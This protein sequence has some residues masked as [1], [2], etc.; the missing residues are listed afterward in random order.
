M[1][2]KSSQVVTVALQMRVISAIG[3][4]SKNS[5]G[6]IFQWQLRDIVKLQRPDWVDS[7]LPGSFTEEGISLPV[8]LVLKNGGLSMTRIIAVSN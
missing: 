3:K 4:R 5:H 8:L 1:S 2:V 7:S 6:R